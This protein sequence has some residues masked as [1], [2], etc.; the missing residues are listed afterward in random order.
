MTKIGVLSVVFALSAVAA[1]AAADTTVFSE[2]FSGAT[3]GTYGS[4]A[5]PGTGF[6]VSGSTVD[7]VGV[8]NGSFY[9]CV[10]NPSGNCVDMVGDSGAGATL[11]STSFGVTAGTTY[12][13]SFTNIL[14]GYNPGDGQTSLFTVSLGGFTQQLTAT[15]TTT[16]NSLSFVAA[17]TDASA[18]LSFH[19][20]TAPDSVHGPVLSAISVTAA[21]PVPEPG[22][23]AMIAGG[24]GL[25]GAFAR[26][27]KA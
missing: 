14:Q 1:P 27:R 24:L 11:T 3:P 23:W 5:L 15:P 20:D 13:I 22:E 26:R 12:T 25:V 9:N 6:S 21:A 18:A 2:D 7:I 19:V 10:A 4:G 8:L 16:G 17:A